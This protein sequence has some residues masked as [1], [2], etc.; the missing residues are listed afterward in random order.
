MPR[1]AGVNR[2]SGCLTGASPPS[3]VDAI[4]APR[5]MGQQRH[6][7]QGSRHSGEGQLPNILPSSVGR[8]V[9]PISLTPGGCGGWLPGHGSAHKQA[10]PAHPE[11]CLA[12]ART[13]HVDCLSS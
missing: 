7:G 6:T 5:G 4:L 8:D 3:G 12:H 11:G 10:L 1:R 13:W 9:G 2:R